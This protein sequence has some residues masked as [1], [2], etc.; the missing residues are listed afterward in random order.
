MSPERKLAE[1]GTKGEVWRVPEMRVGD[2]RRVRI[3]AE[4]A[5]PGDGGETEADAAEAK[6]DTAETET[7]TAKA[8]ADTIYIVAGVPNRARNGAPTAPR[9]N[10]RAVAKMAEDFEKV[11]RHTD[12]K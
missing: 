8:E 3:V 5:S 4:G 11:R 7:D 2:E 12:S 9:L 1:L 10:Q 6:A